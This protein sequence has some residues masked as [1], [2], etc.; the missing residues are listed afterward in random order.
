LTVE[1]MKQL[2][3]RVPDN[4]IITGYRE[5]EHGGKSHSNTPK[6]YRRAF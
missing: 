5:K 2:K 1:N 6:L 4:T 3:I